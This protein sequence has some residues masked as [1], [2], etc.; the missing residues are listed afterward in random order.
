METGSQLRMVADENGFSTIEEF[1]S[2]AHDNDEPD[3]LSAFDMGEGTL[4]IDISAIAGGQAREEVLVDTDE[5]FGMFD[6]VEFVGLGGNQDATLTV[7]YENDRV[8]VSLSEANSGGTG[9]VNIIAT[10]AMVTGMEDDEIWNALIEGKDTYL[11]DNADIPDPSVSKT[12]EDEEPEAEL[13]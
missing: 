11:E 6:D 8:T 2:G 9:Q 7:D 13:A 5:V 12:P 10:G 4:L 3:V 1:R